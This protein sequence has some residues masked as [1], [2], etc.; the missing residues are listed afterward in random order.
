MRLNGLGIKSA[1]RAAGMGS[2]RRDIPA[3]KSGA[4]QFPFPKLAIILAVALTSL[5]GCSKSPS[6]ARA[7][8]QAAPSWDWQKKPLVDRMRLGILPCRVIPKS[9]QNVNSPLT[10]TLRVYVESPQTNI[11]AGFVWARFEPKVF[12]AQ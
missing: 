8:A 4:T 7:A 6:A 3:P 1:R 10:G 11:P 12:E 2:R 9:S 5:I